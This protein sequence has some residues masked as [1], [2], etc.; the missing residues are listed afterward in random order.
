MGNSDGT[1][2]WGGQ[3]MS[4]VQGTNPLSIDTGLSNARSMP[5]TPATTPP[6]SSIQGMQQYQQGSQPYDPSRQM[7]AATTPQQSQYPSNNGTQA[8]ARY[9]QGSYIKSEMGPPSARAVDGVPDHDSKTNNGLMHQGPEQVDNGGEDEE[10]EHEHDGEYTHDSSAA[11]DSSRG[12]YNYTAGSSVGQMPGEHSHLSPELTGS[13]GHQAGSGRATP[14]TAAPP[15]SYYGS[16]AGYAT[17][18]RP[19]PPS[20]NL[21][22][23]MSSERGTANGTS[24]GDVYGAQT[25]L[26]SSISNGYTSQQP[27]LNGVVSNKRA[28]EEDDENTRPLSRDANGDMDGLKRRKTIHEATVPGVTGATFDGGLNRSRSTITQRRGR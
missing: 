5:T 25:D 14:R 17:P 22:N 23:V 7:Y 19:Q 4:N 24:N 2:Q 15:Q 3:N 6:G 10:A 27:V 18:P 8:L 11:Y 16:Q 21:Y 20:S 1:Y 13:P 28:R 12:G 26:V 9:Q